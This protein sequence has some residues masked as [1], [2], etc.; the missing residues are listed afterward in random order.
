MVFMMQVVLLQTSQCHLLDCWFIEHLWI[1][2]RQRY[3][4]NLKSNEKWY[5]IYQMAPE[6]TITKWLSYIRSLHLQWSITFDTFSNTMP[7]T[8]THLYAGLFRHMTCQLNEQHCKLLCSTQHSCSFS[9][10][11]AR[12]N[13]PWVPSPGRTWFLPRCQLVTCCGALLVYGWVVY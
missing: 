7:C 13:S 10:F 2:T 8:V 3:D 6:T 12:P 5:L 4:L 9:T 11:A 1:G